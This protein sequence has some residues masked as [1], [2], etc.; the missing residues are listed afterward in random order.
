MFDA[1]YLVISLLWQSCKSFASLP[2][3]SQ[4]LFFERRGSFRGSLRKMGSGEFE[5]LFRRAMGFLPNVQ[6]C[7][8]LSRRHQAG[9]TFS[10]S[11]A[12]YQ[13]MAMTSV[14]P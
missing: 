4:I 6:L 13:G 3:D 7:S 5:H 1:H 8:R 2:A 11:L 12:V 10:A 9:C 14:G